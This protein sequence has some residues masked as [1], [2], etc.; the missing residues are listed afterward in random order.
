MKRRNTHSV[1]LLLL[2]SLSLI[3]CKKSQQDVNSS[4]LS[5]II[6][7]HTSGLISRASKIQIAFAEDIDLNQIFSEGEIQ[8]KVIDISPKIAGK[9]IQT[10]HNSIVFTPTA[11]LPAN[12]KFKVRIQTSKLKTQNIDSPPTY[13]FEIFTGEQ[14]ISIALDHLSFPENKASNQIDLVLRIQSY[15]VFTFEEIS[16]LIN[17]QLEGAK[18]ELAWQ[19]T[20]NSTTFTLRILNLQRSENRAY[21]T[22]NWSLGA[23]N[24]GQEKFIIPAIGEFDVMQI[25]VES[26]DEYHVLISFSDV[27]DKQQELSGLI[28]ILGYTGRYRFLIENNNI[29]LYHDE[30]LTGVKDIFISENIKSA[31]GKRMGAPLTRSISFAPP[32][33]AVRLVGRGNIIPAYNNQYILP[34]EAINLHSVDIEIFQVFGNNLHQFMQMEYYEESY[35]MYRVGR[36]V[37]QETVKL[38]LLNNKGI[39]RQWQRY[40]I[41]LGTFFTADNQSIYQVRIGFRPEHVTLPCAEGLSTDAPENLKNRLKL[42]SFYEPYYG[43]S[44]SW[45]ENYWEE[46]NNPCNMAYYDRD[47]FVSRTLFATDMGL[48]AKQAGDGA[49]S[50]VVTS[51]ENVAPLSDVSIVLYDYQQQ[52]LYKGTTDA[53]G[54]LSV[55]L[56]GQPFLITAEKGKVKSILKVN[57]GGALQ[58]SRFDISGVSPQNGIKGFIYGDRDVWR[59]GDSLYLNFILETNSKK[60]DHLP[61]NC[62]LR[63]PNGKLI[64]KYVANS[65]DGVLYDLRTATSTDAL[66]G[67]YR[68]NIDVGGASFSKNLKIETIKPNRLRI[69]FKNQE[70]VV[71][72]LNKSISGKLFSEWL[73]GAKAD[74]LKAEIEMSQ[75]DDNTHIGIH[76]TFNFIDPSRKSS[77]TPIKIFEGTLN[78]NGEANVNFK[79][80]SAT[81]LPGRQVLQLKTIVYEKGGDFSVD[82]QTLKYSPFQN[83]VGLQIPKDEY[84][85]NRLEMNKPSKIDLIV[86]DQDGKTVPNKDITISVYRVEWRWW[87]DNYEDYIQS[88][89]SG[90]H[91]NAIQIQSVQTNSN[92]KASLSLNLSQWGRYLIRACNNESGHCSSDFAYVGFPYSDDESSESMSDESNIIQL[93]TAKDKYSP[94]ETIEILIPSATEGK[95]LVSIETG[96]SILESTWHP[97]SN[98]NNKIN[99]KATAEMA[100]NIYINGMLVQAHMKMASHQPL[101]M[102]GI[103]PVTIEHKESRL[104]PQIKMPNELEGDRE[105]TLEVSEKDGQPMSY[106]IAIVDEGLLNITRFKTPNPHGYFFAKEALGVRTWDFY[107]QILSRFYGGSGRMLSVGGDASVR[108]EGTPS[109]NR[110]PPVV[111]HSGPFTLE[112]NKKVKHVFKMPNYSGSVR[113]MV[114]AAHHKKYGHAEKHVA[115][116]KP[117]MALATIPRVLGPGEEFLMPIN[118][119]SLDKKVQQ[120]SI[121]VKET[122]G[123]V[124][125]P[126]GQTASVKFSQSGEEIVFI[127]VKV[128]DQ[129]GIAKFIIEAKGDGHSATYEVELLVRNPN[130][131]EIQSYDFVLNAGSTQNPSIDMKNTSGDRTVQ[132]LFSK[133]PTI[134]LAGQLQYLIDYPH[135]CLEQTISKALPMLFVGEVAELSQEQTRSIPIFIREAIAKIQ[136]NITSEG[137]LGNWPGQSIQPWVTTYALHFLAI[138]DQKGYLIDKKIYNDLQRGEASRSKSWQINKSPSYSSSNDHLN[139][140]A[141]RLFV[142]AFSGKPELASMNLLREQKELKNAA[143][144]MLAGAYGLSGREEIGKK[145]IQGKKPEVFPYDSPGYN[146]GSILRDKSLIFQSLQ[147]LKQEKEMQ[148]LGLEL[149]EGLNSSSFYSTQTLAHI[150]MAITTYY[151]EQSIDESLAFSYSVN[152][153]KLLGVVGKK[154]LMIIDL[155]NENNQNLELKLVNKMKGKLYVKVNTNS[156]PKPGDETVRSN[157][158]SIQVTYLDKNGNEINVDQLAHGTDFMAK[159]TITRGNKA[160]NYYKDIAVTQIFPSGW[161]ISNSRMSNQATAA[162]PSVDFQ[163]IRDDRVLTYLNLSN[164]NQV[165][166]NI[167]LKA[168]YSGRFY[169]PS[170]KCESMYFEIVQSGTKGKWVEVLKNKVYN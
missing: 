166:F 151:K 61:V 106:T 144:F 105:F 79:L 66:I 108:I 17:I 142:L 149:I 104:S 139:Q 5:N 124:T 56:N 146:Y 168:V 46:R 95:A 2:L 3:Q 86:V 96:K 132:I 164:T 39:T 97:I 143:L 160:P 116:R 9:W 127:P 122:N 159:T 40:G 47:H 65:N 72:H 138:A 24:K 62:E 35:N 13:E 84:G 22:V 112:K 30:N 21:A 8:K 113:V 15:D 88:Y 60:T 136:R 69:D 120:A 170:H 73:H 48:V 152:K 81:P 78:E 109:P 119:F 135:G 101:R 12:T 54:K 158:I 129:T 145:L 98:G 26:D 1:L 29:R 134:D 102:Y 99:I 36:L 153:A 4:L 10:G 85:Q 27:L 42:E 148:Q 43:W 128:K 169:L 68:F 74:A 130:P 157:D 133:F 70:A 64:K 44:G 77:H 156:I 49:W 57:E 121:Q 107:D 23:D 91:R 45:T 137:A 53:L 110:F 41:D 126:G 93:K 34:I 167:P 80:P 38:E 33:P 37:H 115:V 125:F 162:A 141:Y 89:N 131:S 114:V 55:Q 52:I 6:S 90:N 161:E 7:G 82:Y 19:N 140:Q 28:Q 100:P 25:N 14:R 155:P 67:N 150:L 51:L 63:D 18:P 20:S 87:W 76:S 94:G 16:G 59:P 118:L 163:D 92:G 71:S 154:D 75:A 83:Y 103:I 32:K 50:V 123:L 11:L 117:L 31:S 111:I 147:I 165:T 58:L